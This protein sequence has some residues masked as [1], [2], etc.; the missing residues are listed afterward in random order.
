[1][2]EWFKPSA[3]QITAFVTANFPEAKP[4]KGGIEF[5]INNPFDGDTGK[6][7]NIGTN[8]FV[9]DWRGDEWAGPPNPRTGKRT[10]TFLNFVRL[11]LGCSYHDAIRAVAGTGTIPSLKRLMS[12][13]DTLEKA[14]VAL[15][16]GSE[17][18]WLSSQKLAAQTVLS[19]LYSRGI[20]DNMVKVHGIHHVGTDVVFPYFEFSQLCYWQTRSLVNKVFRFPSQEL[21]GV[22]K[23]QFLYNF[24]HIEPA[25]YLVVVEAIFGCHT[26]G[27]QTVASGGAILTPTQV[28]KM[29]LLGPRDGIILGPDNDIAGIKS[30]CD[31]AREM[32]GLGYPLFYSLPPMLP[33]VDEDGTTKLTK[34]WNE[35]VTKLHWSLPDIRSAFEKAIVPLTPAERFKLIGKSMSSQK[36]RIYE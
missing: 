28:K 36:K 16:V 7:F 30:I 32:D 21:Y 3:D 18:L 20:D 10:C 27:A 14:L 22:T 31:N 4:R 9:H 2:T 25:S 26:L 35:L 11:Y 33:Y 24:D 29:K 13:P 12:V 5:R 6:H 19:W 15:P 34:D 17:P 1:M 8:G 23:G